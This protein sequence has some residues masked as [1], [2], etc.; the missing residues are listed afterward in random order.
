M[1]ELDWRKSSFSE[2]MG[3]DC[4]ELAGAPTLIHLR[5][6]DDP[7]VILTTTPQTLRALING[8]KR[9]RFDDIR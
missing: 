8:I 6:S 3:N 5:E 9:G 2:A 7:N 1:H 4:V